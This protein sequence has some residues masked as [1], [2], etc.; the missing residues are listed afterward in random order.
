MRLLA[1]HHSL[2][3]EQEGVIS[4]KRFALV[5]HLK[6]LLP[7]VPSKEMNSG[8]FDGRGIALE[9]ASPSPG[10][11]RMKLRQVS[12]LVLLCAAALGAQQPPAAPAASQPAPPS[13]AAPN[14]APIMF[15]GATPV[16]TLDGICDPSA[17]PSSKTCTTVITHGQIASLIDALAPD[18][19]PDERRRFA[20]RYAQLVSAAGEAQKKHLDKLPAVAAEL[21]AQ[22]ELLRIQ[23]LTK[24][25]YRQMEEDAAKVS[26]ADIQKYYE[27][28]S[29][30]FAE[31]ELKVL[32]VPAGY[33]GRE[34]IESRA[35]KGEDLAELQKE[36][37]KE[38]KIDTPDQPVSRGMV[39]RSALSPEEAKVFDRKPG[40]AYKVQD[41]NGDYAILVL[42]SLRI[43][44]LPEVQAAI[45]ETLRQEHLDQQFQAAREDV[46]GQFN[47]AYIGATTPPDLFPPSAPARPTGSAAL[48]LA[49]R[50][51]R[52]P[53]TRPMPPGAR[54]RMPT[55]MPPM[56]PRP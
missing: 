30:E 8:F 55:A 46:K 22:E 40:E 4:P 44:P 42:G 12:M 48:G 52:R 49:P 24:A 6:S 29:A 33:P 38:M 47:L 34:D 45:M 3:M 28:H 2:G 39:R 43:L 32:S 15:A 19:S 9:A 7:R 14:A 1:A 10:E 36:M 54:G 41:P 16:V 13:V 35:S 53:G 25:L 56:Q 11:K 17:G 26:P 5:I 27:D 18:S 50:S 31:G 23:V 37:L 21:R 51:T 20:I